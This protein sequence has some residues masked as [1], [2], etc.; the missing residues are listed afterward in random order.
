[1]LATEM[2]RNSVPGTELEES[3]QIIPSF[4]ASYLED[5]LLKKVMGECYYLGNIGNF[6]GS[7]HKKNNYS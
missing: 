7:S 1:M 2:V 3:L 6:F 4:L 5:G